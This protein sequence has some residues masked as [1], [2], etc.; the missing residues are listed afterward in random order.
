MTSSEIH[1]KEPRTYEQQLEIL[2]ERNLVIDDMDDAISF[3]KR[4]SYYRF[5][6]YG[7]TLK[8][9]DNKDLFLE[10]VS[11]FQMKMIYNFDQK[12]RDLLMNH[13]EL[14]EIEFRSKIAYHHS[15]QF[16]ALG[17]KYPD[18]FSSP[19]AH[20]RFL[21]ELDKQINRSGKELFVLHHKSKYGGEFPFWVAIEVISFGE[22]SKL[23]KNLTEEIKG[24]IVNDFNLSSFYAESW[25][26]TLSYIR[27]VCAHYGR[28][29]GKEL[30]IKPKVFKSKRNKFKANRIF[31][32]MFILAK[33]LH[34]EDRLNFITTF[35]VLLEEYSD[36]I[37]LKELGLPD[38]WERLLLEH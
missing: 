20:K 35:Q 17:Y 36:H 7:L 15:H 34:R 4:V 18:N 19:V 23:F 2:Q 16:G 38:D 29:Y 9:N 25:L 33:L 32:A 21:E 6:A 14:V 3:L 11:F 24:E 27:N 13:L 26:H 10:G 1:I 22:L 8:Q 37:V 31:T 28:I 5:S 30:A 12:L